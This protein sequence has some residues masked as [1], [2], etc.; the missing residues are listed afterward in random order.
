MTFDHKLFRSLVVEGEQPFITNADT[1]EAYR[2]FLITK[3]L[4]DTER[5]VTPQTVRWWLQRIE[6]DTDGTHRRLRRLASAYYS[7][8]KVIY[9]PIY[10]S[11]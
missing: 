2:Q 7:K 6:H 4:S 10:L 9:N 11:E 1:L 3:G 5:P 8:S